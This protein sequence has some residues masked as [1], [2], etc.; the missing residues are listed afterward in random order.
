MDLGAYRQY[1]GIQSTGVQGLGRMDSLKKLVDQ[2]LG[3]GLKF[4]V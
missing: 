1:L 2:G 3:L 4:R